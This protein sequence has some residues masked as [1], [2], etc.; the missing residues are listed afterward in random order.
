MHQLLNTLYLT[1]EG[2]YLR[3]DHDTLRV[4]VE[5]ETKLQVPIHH[6]GG[7]VCFG[8]V[9]VSP[10]ALARCAQDGRSRATC[11]CVAHN[12]QPSAMPTKP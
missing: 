4:E 11:Y 8:D 6:L 7:I 10:A 3:L 9:L 12:M 1:T 5:R 2:A